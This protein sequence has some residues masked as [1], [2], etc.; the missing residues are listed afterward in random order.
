MK[1]LLI[2]IFLGW[3]GGYRF[4][5]KQPFLGIVYLL[6][7][8]FFGI[9]WII[10]ILAA[11]KAM[12]RKAKPFSVEIDIRG[13]FAECKKDPR[14]KRWSVV[15]G[16][17]VGTELGVEIAYYENKPYYQLLAPS[18]LDIGAFPSEISQTLLRDYPNCKITAKLTNK[19]DPEHPFAQIH[20]SP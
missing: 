5:K 14:I 19:A 2:A 8:G 12:P 4:Y 10:D 9:G 16:L 18:G 1:G 11:L 6:T 13:S 3:L 17:D 15:N 20:V 7:F